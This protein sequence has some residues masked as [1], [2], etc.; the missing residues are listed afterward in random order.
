[1]VLNH[2]MEKHFITAN[3]LLL[4][5]FKL[6]EQIYAR[7]YKPQFIIGVW[8]GGAPVGI[9]VQ[10]YLDFMGVDTNHIAI[11]TSS[12]Y[13]INQQHREIKI[14]G[15]DYV[16]N[17]VEADQEL[18]IVDDV[19]DSGRSIKAIIDEIK[20]RARKNTPNT[21]KT[22]CTWYKPNRNITDLTPDFYVHATDKWLIFPH[23]IKG[24]SRQEILAGKGSEI[25]GT[26]FKG[27]LQESDLQ[28]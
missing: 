6:A 22:A 14:H 23:E 8:R 7:N 26:I 10:E 28:E 3:D 17:H 11:R 20:K 27:D 15:L 12:Y 24:L 9:A 18:L 19:F 21:I 1:M 16:I 2:T 25:A 5:S 4:D 13:G